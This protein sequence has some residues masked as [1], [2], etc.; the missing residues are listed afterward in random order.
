LL[1]SGAV[2]HPGTGDLVGCGRYQLDCVMAVEDPH[3]ADGAHPPTQM[4]F[5]ERPAGQ[6]GHDRVD[7][8]A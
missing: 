2:G 7:Q 8:L 5:Q 4:R 3:I 6:V 1:A